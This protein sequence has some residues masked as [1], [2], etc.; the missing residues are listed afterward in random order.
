MCKHVFSFLQDPQIAAAQG[1]TG[2]ITTALALWLQTVALEKVPAAEMRYMDTQEFP[3]V[4]FMQ[5]AHVP[6]RYVTGQSFRTEYYTVKSVGT[7]ALK[8]VALG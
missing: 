3:F 8:G 7:Q 1:Y 5:N 4:C 6:E 2:L